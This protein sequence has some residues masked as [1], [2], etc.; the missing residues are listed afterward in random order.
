MINIIYDDSKCWQGIP[1]CQA[2]ISKSIIKYL[3][4]NLTSDN[5]HSFTNAIIDFLIMG[6]QTGWRGVE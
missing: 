4:T 2:P 5:S 1:N 6:L 3:R